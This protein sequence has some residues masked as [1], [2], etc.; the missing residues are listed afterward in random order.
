MRVDFTDKCGDGSSL[1]VWGADLS[2]LPDVE[3]MVI[4]T[5]M[6]RRFKV[7]EES[8]GTLLLTALGLPAN[9]RVNFL[10]QEVEIR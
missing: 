10:G 4:Q 8:D 3:G 6:G 1:E 2:G 9:V 7:R 5:R